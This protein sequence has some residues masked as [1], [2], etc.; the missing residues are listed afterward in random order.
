MQLDVTVCPYKRVCGCRLQNKEKVE[1]DGDWQY[2]DGLTDDSLNA[3]TLPGRAR[4]GGKI[5]RSLLGCFLVDQ[6][7]MLGAKT[8]LSANPYQR[9]SFKCM[10][11]RRN[12]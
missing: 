7:G 1:S 6:G 4:K 3:C 5:G 10:P 12:S 2:A 9:G 8:C 11:V